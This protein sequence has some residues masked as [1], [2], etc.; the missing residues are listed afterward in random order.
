MLD[1]FL[2]SSQATLKVVLICAGGAYLER[3]KIFDKTIRRGITEAFVKLL[4]P[5]LLFTR[6]LPKMSTDMLPIMGWLAFGNI[7]YVTVGSVIGAI[8]V[9]ATQPAPRLRKVLRIVPA[10]GHGNSIP[11]MMVALLCSDYEGFE[12]GDADRAQGYIGLYL[13]MHSITLWGVGLNVIKK[14][15]DEDLPAAS[16]AVSNEKEG[17]NPQLPPQFLGR[18][19]GS[20]TEGTHSESCAEHRQSDGGEASDSNT[21]S[22]ESF[23]DIASTKSSEDFPGASSLAES[24][25]E[26]WAESVSS[27]EMGAVPAIQVRKRFRCKPVSPSSRIPPWVNRAMVAA[28]VATILGL[29]LPVQTL[30]AIKGNFV[31]EAMEK[32]GEAGPTWALLSVGA[33]FVAD[34]VPKPSAIGYGPL[35]GAILGRLL[36]LP[37]CCI[38]LWGCMR[39]AVSFF[40]ND[41]VLMLVLCLEC[42]TP[43]AYNLVT[44]CVL[45]GTGAKELAAALFYQNVAAIFTMT[46]WVSVILYFVI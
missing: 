27:L 19:A 43:S 10:I 30:M 25:E 5:C 44:I 33:L 13:V 12:A 23:A 42:V 11:F 36:L 35:A 28:L 26:A 7:F 34:G 37:A 31:F 24:R 2:L 22:A 8:S 16:A 6:I 21:T 14:E 29:C 45:Q 4:L 17:D 39:R 38:F 9:W 40:P 15:R 41:R 1:V 20:G 32:L 18:A 3:A 46:A